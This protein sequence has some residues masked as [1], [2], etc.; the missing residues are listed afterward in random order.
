MGLSQGKLNIEDDDALKD[1]VINESND[2]NR[3]FS[4]LSMDMHGNTV[5]A[6]LVGITVL[7]LVLALGFKIYT[8]CFKTKSDSRKKE[9]A[10]TWRSPWGW[11]RSRNEPGRC[12]TVNTTQGRLIVLHHRVHHCSPMP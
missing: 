10:N 9:T 6:T 2:E 8:K 1:L 3:Y 7:V 4:V 12:N 5:I 11:N